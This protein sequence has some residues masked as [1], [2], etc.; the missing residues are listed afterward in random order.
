MTCSTSSR[1]PVENASI[2]LRICDSTRPPICSTPERSPSSSL[3]YCFEMCSLAMMPPAGSAETAGDVVLGLLALRLDEDL[4]GDAE[5]DHLAEVHVGSV[6]RDPRRLLH[7]VRHHD[8]G[9][10]LLQL[11]HE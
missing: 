2:A 4:V 6:V 1:P 5:L 11:V 3:S 8:D 7:V 10:I 9:V